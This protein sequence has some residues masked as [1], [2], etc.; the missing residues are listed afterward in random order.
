MAWDD[1]DWKGT[2][3]EGRIARDRADPGF[4]ARQRGFAPA[5][6]GLGVV[7]LVLLVVVLVA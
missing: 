3:P 7:L 5:A 1:D 4:W 6:A 2:P